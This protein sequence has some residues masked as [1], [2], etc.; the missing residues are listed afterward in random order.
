MEDQKVLSNDEFK[1]LVGSTLGI[2]A[3]LF[4]IGYLESSSMAN[5]LLWKVI[6]RLGITGIGVATMQIVSKYTKEYTD[7]HVVTY[8]TRVSEK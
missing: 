7:E 2:S 3:M 1:E 6:R 4:V 8:N 5:G